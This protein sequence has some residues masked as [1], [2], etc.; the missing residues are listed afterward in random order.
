[1]SD[2][3][4]RSCLIG[5]VDTACIISIRCIIPMPSLIRFH[6]DFASVIPT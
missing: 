3:V 4:V 5:N 1:M 2:G 6:I